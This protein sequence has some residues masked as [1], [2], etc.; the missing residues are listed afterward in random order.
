[1]STFDEHDGR[2]FTWPG[3]STDDPRFWSQLAV[4]KIFAGNRLSKIDKIYARRVNNV[5]FKVD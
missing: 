3:T 1:M 5:A 4:L 2:W